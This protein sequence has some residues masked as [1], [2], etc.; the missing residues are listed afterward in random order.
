MSD[1]TIPASTAK[2][3]AWW[4]RGGDTVTDPLPQELA[5]ADLLDP[6]PPTLREQ[7]ARIGR[8]LA[9]A[10]ATSMSAEMAE[11]VAGRYADA[12]LAVVA[13]WLAAQPLPGDNPDRVER[14]QRDHDVRLLRGDA[15]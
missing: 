10:G 5:W 14:R 4:L 6:Q 3:I 7:L 9:F 12:V 13:D 1:V 11:V 8:G 2:E 15:A